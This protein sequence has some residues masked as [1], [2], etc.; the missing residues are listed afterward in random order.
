MITYTNKWIINLL[1][2]HRQRLLAE[3]VYSR[4]SISSDEKKTGG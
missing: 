4:L 3:V 2:F 1:L